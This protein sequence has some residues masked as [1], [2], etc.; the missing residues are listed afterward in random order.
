MH[1]LAK[2]QVSGIQ[3]MQSR[4]LW[5]AD[6]YAQLVKYRPPEITKQYAEKLAHLFTQSGQL[7]AWDMGAGKTRAGLY[8]MASWATLAMRMENPEFRR[9]MMRPMMVLGEASGVHVWKNQLASWF[10]D[11]PGDFLFP[12]ETGAQVDEAIDLAYSGNVKA[13]SVSYSMVSRYVNKFERLRFSLVIADEIQ[14]LTNPNTQRAQALYRLARFRDDAYPGIIFKVGLSG[15]PFTNKVADLW[16]VLS[17]LQGVPKARKVKGETKYHMVST[18][19]GS[20]TQFEDM[21]VDEKTGLGGKNILHDPKK[22]VSCNNHSEAECPNLHPKM[23]RLIMHRV[24]AEEA[25]PNLPFVSLEWVEATMPPDQAKLYDTL[26]SDM[27]LPAIDKE[28][29]AERERAVQRLALMT[30][31]FECLA[32]GRQLQY[33]LRN[34][35]ELALPFGVDES[36]ILDKVVE[37]CDEIPDPE[38]VVIFTGYEQFANQIAERLAH[39]NPIVLAG[40]TGRAE[41]AERDFQNKALGHR[42]FVSTTRGIKAITLTKARYCIVAGFLSYSPWDILQAIYRIRRPGQTADR[43]MVYG[44]TIEGTLLAWLRA[45][46][47]KKLEYGLQVLDGATGGAEILNIQDM[48]RKQFADA[49]RGK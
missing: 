35:P 6:S 29:G 43:L 15:T 9:V 26:I 25:W 18:N 10:P 40:Q 42:A 17:F 36:G 20:R 37:I 3:I 13:L 14:A 39:M 11:A 23:L 12:I 22:Y 33:S 41:D 47:A 8:I 44:I 27:V 46:L 19:W 5:V 49:F 48:T 2:H 38:S 1:P 4:T 24:T 7:L 16:P 32:S 45:R 28:F 21:Y 30:Y 31:A 34:S